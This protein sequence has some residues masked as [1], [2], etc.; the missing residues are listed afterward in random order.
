MLLEVKDNVKTEAAVLWSVR[1]LIEN[2]HI[3]RTRAYQMV[4]SP[5]MPTV[6]IGGRVFI[7]RKQ[8]IEMLEQN[9]RNRDRP[10]FDG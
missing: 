4:K 3:S 1:D 9:A 6:Y 5:E 7:L 8:F 10:L 2:C